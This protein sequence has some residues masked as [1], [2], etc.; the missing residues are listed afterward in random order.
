MKRLKIVLICFVYLM[1]TYLVTNQPIPVSAQTAIGDGYLGEIT[2]VAY[3]FSPR[4][5]MSCDG[6]ILP[7]SQNTALFSLIGT[8]Y[9]GDGRTTFALPDLRGFQPVEGS[10]YVINVLGIYPARPD[11]LIS[12]NLLGTEITMFPYS[13]VPD[14]AYYC[15]GYSTFFT[16]NAIPDLRGVELF[17]GIKYAMNTEAYAFD[18]CMGDILIYPKDG[19]YNYPNN[20]LDCAGQVLN[21]NSNQALYSILGTTYGGDGRTT[22]ALPDLTDVSPSPDTKY[23]IV[24]NGIYPSRD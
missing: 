21:I 18:Y 13:F 11:E 15:D 7:I 23:V 6:K 1:T 9:G 19:V 3:A 4:G 2:L 14:R 22:F 17:P 12:D 24:I 5:T 8:I 16:G 20:L 10:H